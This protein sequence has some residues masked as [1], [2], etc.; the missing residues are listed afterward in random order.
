MEKKIQRDASVSQPEKIP[1]LNVQ[2]L[3]QQV[4]NEIK[5]RNFEKALTS[6]KSALDLEPNNGIIISQ[7]GYVHHKLKYKYVSMEEALNLCVKGLNLKPDSPLVNNNLAV[8]YRKKKEYESAI[9]YSNKSLSLNP[10]FIPALINLSLVY[11]GDKAIE[12]CKK[13]L[14][15]D[16]KNATAWLLLGDSYFNMIRHD[17]LTKELYLSIES[18][19]KCLELDNDGRFEKKINQIL[20]SLANIREKLENKRDHITSS[21]EELKKLKKDLKIGVY[22]INL[23]KFKESLAQLETKNIDAEIIVRLLALSGTKDSKLGHLKSI[24]ARNSG[25]SI[26]AACGS[27]QIAFDDKYQNTFD[28]YCLECGEEISATSWKYPNYRVY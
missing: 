3:I 9:K 15:I 13:I 22:T 8:L 14:A 11:N 24:L 5:A 18:F 28:F 12:F 21:L 10:N 2:F 26:C 19:Q 23:S 16:S 17:K 25:I 20:I 1:E 6:L 7:I 4:E 27:D